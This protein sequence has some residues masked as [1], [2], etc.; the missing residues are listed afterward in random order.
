M[1]KALTPQEMVTALRICGNHPSMADKDCKDCPFRHR[2][3]GG[4]EAAMFDLTAA[5]IIED[6]LEELALAKAGSKG[7]G[8]EDNAAGA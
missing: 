8:G 7:N 6:L 2:C 5:Q 4:R 1:E 3:D